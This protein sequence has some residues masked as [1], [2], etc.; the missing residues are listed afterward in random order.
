[1]DR[2]SIIKQAGIAGVLAA[3]IAPAVHA[4]ATVRW[5]LAS[6]FPKSLDT[7]FGS[8]EM[9]AKTVRALSGG[10]FEV[11]VHAAGELMPAFGVV[12]A[13]QSSTIEMAQTAPYYYTGKNSIFA[14]GCAVPFGLTARQMDAW[15]DHGN[16]RKLM[17][18][19]YANYNIKSRSAGNTGTQMGGWYR[20]EIKTVADLKGLKFRMGGGLF[21]EAMQKL[22][23]VPQNMPAGDVYQA[24]EKGTLDATEFVGPYD[25]EKLGFNKVAPFYYYPGWWEGGAELEFF[26]NAKAYAALPAEFQAIVDAATTVAARDMTAKYDAFNPIALKRLVAAKTQLKAFPK[27]I[28]DAGYKASMEVFAEHEAKSPEFKTIHQDMRAFQRDQLLWARYSELRFD[29]YMTGV[30]L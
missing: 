20:K 15:M 11:S 2:R 12:D 30:K 29:N 4:Q 25:D 22:G 5:R 23:V 9:F 14:F 24:L 8:A 10:K 27:E 1:M 17:D 6:S 16:G 26:I 7:I 21:G 19:F 13:L 28:M 18:A 3:G